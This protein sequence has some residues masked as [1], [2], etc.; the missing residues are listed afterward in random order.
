[1]GLSIAANGSNKHV[2]IMQIH[3]DSYGI[4]QCSKD[5]TKLYCQLPPV[6]QPGCVAHQFF[7][8]AS[9]KYKAS[10]NWLTT[11]ARH[12]SGKGEDV[13]R[14]HKPIQSPHGIEK[15]NLRGCHGIPKAQY[16]TRSTSNTLPHK[17]SRPM[18]ALGRLGDGKS[19]TLEGCSRVTGEP[20][21]LISK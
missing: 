15:V 5:G 2:L 7:L 11:S 9:W 19:S 1:M 20:N 18:I 3:V 13:C 6:Q 8:A 10:Q 17:N 16:I 14:L 12:K 21:A 4:P